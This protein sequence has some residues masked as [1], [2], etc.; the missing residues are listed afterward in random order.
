MSKKDSCKNCEQKWIDT[1]KNDPDWEIRRWQARRLGEWGSEAAVQP[2][3]DAADDKSKKVQLEAI[4]ALIKIYPRL[5]GKI[6][7]ALI[8]MQLK[9]NTYEIARKVLDEIKEKFPN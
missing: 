6:I 8:T 3:C 2:L 4:K 9:P 7:H 5:K 1:L